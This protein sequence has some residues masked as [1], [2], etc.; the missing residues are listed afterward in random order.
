MSLIAQ[1]LSHLYIDE[2]YR[3]NAWD[4]APSLLV[5]ATLGGTTEIEM[6]LIARA[7]K[8]GDIVSQ[9][10]ACYREQTLPMYMSLYLSENFHDNIL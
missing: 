3:D 8:E 7:S 1:L 6:I 5:L 2:V 10:H 9:N 4:I